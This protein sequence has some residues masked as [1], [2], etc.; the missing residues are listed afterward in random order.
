MLKSIRARM[1]LLFVMSV[2][3]AACA[4]SPVAPASEPVATES[5]PMPAP[6]MP[7]AVPEPEPTASRA[8]E[9]GAAGALA[10]DEQAAYYVSRLPRPSDV[11]A[12]WRMDRTPQYQERMPAPGDT[13]RFACE[14]LPARSVGLATVG[15]RSLDALPSMTI[16]YVIYPTAGDAADALEDMRRAM[17]ACPEFAIRGDA[18]DTPDARFTP[19]DFPDYGSGSFGAA[20]ETETSATG[21][22]VTHVIKI[23]RGNVVVGINH[24]NWGDQPPPDAAITEQ[25]AGLTL[26][27]LGRED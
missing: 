4:T 10:F 1:F 6:A 27:Y 2:M 26:D 22:L 13:Y 7:T 17:T 11:P 9:P 20:L 15:Y 23:Q 18:D 16:E 3:L 8:D 19:L 12:G 24:A 5:P 14:E 21:S 25:M